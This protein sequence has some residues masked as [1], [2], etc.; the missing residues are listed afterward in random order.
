MTRTP[1]G[2]KPVHL[3]SKQ[4]QSSTGLPS[5]G[6][7]Q[8]DCAPT[9]L[10]QSIRFRNGP[11]TLAGLLSKMMAEG[12]VH[13]TQPVLTGPTHFQCVP[14]LDWFTFPKELAES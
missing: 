10:R 11:G 9:D 2:V 12:G 3:F 13:A 7:E 14:V 1:T 4:R 6:G 8:R 5:Y